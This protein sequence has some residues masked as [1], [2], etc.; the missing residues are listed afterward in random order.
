MMKLNDKPIRFENENLC[1]IK[2]NYVYGGTAIIA[3]TE[4]EVPYAYVSVNLSEY[5][6]IPNED[7]IYLDHNL[8]DEFVEMFKENFVE[9]TVGYCQGGWVLFECVRLKKGLI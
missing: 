3:M 6:T 4:D 5:G 2:T 7:C 1:F 8:S 9:E